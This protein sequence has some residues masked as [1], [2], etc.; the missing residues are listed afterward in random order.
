MRSQTRASDTERSSGGAAD[1]LPWAG[2]G[3][4]LSGTGRAGGPE[5]LAALAWSRYRRHALAVAG[6]AV[7]FALFAACFGAPLFVSANNPNQVRVTQILQPPSVAH[8]FGTDDVGRDNLLRAIF[9]GRISLQ[10]GLLSALISVGIGVAVGGMAGY[11]GG[12]VDTV[13]MRF[14]DALLSI[15][16]LFILIVLTHFIGQTVAAITAVIGG[17]SWMTVCRLVRANVLSLKQED[18]VAAARSIG[19]RPSA[20]LVRHLLPNSMG[21]VVVAATLGVGQAII[22]EASLSFLGLGV[23]PPTATWG[24]MLERAQGLLAQ[25]PWMA[26]FPGLLILIAVLSVNLVGEGLQDAL[27]PRSHE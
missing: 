11:H 23:Q 16:T 5:S 12:W 27:D 20:I 3:G 4:R 21:P 25:A 1:G 6:G 7:L 10:V 2:P 24:N 17:L 13:L 22:F 26:V 18:F 9:G 14:T 8:P 19:A 15:P